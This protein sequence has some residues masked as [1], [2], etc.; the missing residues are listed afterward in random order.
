MIIVDSVPYGG[1]GVVVAEQLKVM[2]EVS[3]ERFTLETTT[4]KAR[5]AEMVG[6]WE[7]H[8]ETLKMQCVS[9]DRALRFL[10]RFGRSKGE[11]A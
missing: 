11:T 6:K 3:G 1:F 8:S 2:L 10:G 5:A 7:R 4:N 9:T